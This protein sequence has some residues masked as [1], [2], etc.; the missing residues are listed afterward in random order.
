MSENQNIFFEL[1]QVAVG[2]R[3]VLSSAPSDD[4]W[5][6]IYELTKRHT[7]VGIAFA[8]IE[9]LPS[10]QMPPP[11]RI[12]QWAIKADR[13]K[14]LNQRISRQTAEL[15]HF[16]NDNGFNCITLKGQGNTYYY[17]AQLKDLRTPGD[18]DVWVWPKGTDRNKD[19][20]NVIDFCLARKKGEF[21]YYHNL[22]FPFFNDTP[23]EVHYRP[24]WL[25]TPWLNRRLQKWF[26]RQKD[27][28]SFIEHDGF[29]IPNADFNIV[30]QLLHLYK[31]IFEEGIG[32]RQLLDYYTVMTFAGRTA[33]KDEL[34]SLIKSFGM[35][36]F[37]RA[38]T[39]VIQTVFM[40]KDDKWMLC[41]PD[42]KEGNLLLEEIMQGGNF[43][44]HDERYHWSEV[45]NGSMHYRGMSY[46]ITRLRHNMHFLRS[47]PSEVLFEP[48]FRLY[49]KIWLR[50]KLWH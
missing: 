31:H 32:L 1:L 25:Y 44:K 7:L 38:V 48:F 45:T 34:L 20:T 28:C 16:F 22:D 26:N 43:G 6:G 29:I 35:L 42:E 17:P 37:L 49:N 47:Y 10:E 18:I 46:A 40:P 27:S 30:F 36:R 50:L 24:S 4:D 19:V 15:T 12:R 33:G 21:V 3:T 13:Q 8:G 39:Y 23:V 5:E 14:N 9:R 11:R 2:N 41:N